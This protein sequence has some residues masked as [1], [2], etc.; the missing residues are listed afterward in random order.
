MSL[1]EDSSDTTFPPVSIQHIEN[2][3]FSSWYPKFS[4]SSLRSII[5]PLP[6]AFINY[7]HADGVFLPRDVGDDDEDQFSDSDDEQSH[8]IS[9]PPGPGGDEEADETES[10]APSFPE[11]Q[12][13]IEEA[14]ED[15]GGAVFPKLNWSSPKDAAWVAT[16][17]T[18]K[19]TTVQDIFLLLKSSDFIVHDLDHAYDG[20][21][22][23]ETLTSP[24]RGAPARATSFDLVLRKWYD[25][26]PSMEF[27]CFVKDNHLIGVTQRDAVNYYDF[28]P[29]LQDELRGYIIRFFETKVKENFADSSYVFDVY[30]NTR[31]HRVSL[32][33]F[34][35]F[36]KTTDSLLFD[37]SEIIAA[38]PQTNPEQ[39]PIFRIITSN[40]Q[41]SQCTYPTYSSSRLPRD[42]ID[43]SDGQSIQ[44]FAEDFRRQL[45]GAMAD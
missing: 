14:I 27:R 2:C 7:L 44:Q 32:V 28:L 6:E 23:T 34:N 10:E 24:T 9:T 45:D 11:L 42:T 3:S 38:S 1:V 4:S 35:A 20:C 15:L 21:S 13:Q 12:K 5:I 30:I 29:G 39:Y 36:S 18:L 16:G 37:W 31:N 26:A 33:D 25:L 8:N 40:R 22:Q 43:L 41:A 17:S 19:C